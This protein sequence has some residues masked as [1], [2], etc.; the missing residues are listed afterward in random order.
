ML[1]KQ[2]DKSYT[3]DLSSD[4]KQ[5]ARMAWNP[6]RDFMTKNIFINRRSF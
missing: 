1:C 4:K 3:P 2:D 5:G 6:R